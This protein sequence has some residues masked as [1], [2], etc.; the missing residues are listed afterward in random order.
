M[1]DYKSCMRAFK[2]YIIIPI[3]S[4]VT[5]GLVLYISKSY[6]F[7][8]IPLVENKTLAIFQA[9]VFSFFPVVILIAL[10]QILLGDPGHITKK[11]VFKIY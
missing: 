4:L 1:V 10:F 9:V 5:M 7:N 8:Y 3:T 6:L 11:M 2:K